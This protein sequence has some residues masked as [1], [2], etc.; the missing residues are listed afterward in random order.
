M[1]KKYLTNGFFLVWSI[2]TLIVLSIIGS[3][4]YSDFSH[5]KKLTS[6]RFD[7]STRWKLHHFIGG[8]CKCS[9]F[10][11]D[12][13]IKRKTQL[14][15]DEEIVIFDD[16]KDF[17]S[18]LIKSG[19]NAKSI[20]YENYPKEN[21]PSGFPILL[22]TSPSGEA[23]YEGGYSE[24]MINPFTKFKDLKLLS[25]FREKRREIAS[26]PAYGCYSAQ[27]YRKKLDPLGLK[28]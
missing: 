9:E 23:V 4:H 25:Q 10:I 18:R 21:R 13:L 22:I 6:I 8:D 15:I 11:V 16:V 27:K 20:S 2:S 7:P 12:Y 28:Y 24:K 17:K 19:F 1:I 26:L 14:D 5:Q 3:W